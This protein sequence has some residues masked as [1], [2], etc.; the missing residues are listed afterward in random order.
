M[1]LFITKMEHCYVTKIASGIV[2]LPIGCK[3]SDVDNVVELTIVT[4]IF[5]IW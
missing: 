2:S 1:V 3:Y 4:I 5:F